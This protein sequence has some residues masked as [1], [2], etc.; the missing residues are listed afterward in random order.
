ML[1]SS[2]T[3]LFGFLPAVLALYFFLPPLLSLF[4]RGRIPQQHLHAAKN[5]VLLLSSLFFYAFGEPLYV[6]LMLGT[7][8]ADFLFGL[9]L[10]KSKKPRLV[11][12]FAVIFNL[13]LLFFFK[14]AAFFAAAIGVTVTPPRLPLGISFYTFQALSYV[15]DVYRRE[16]APTKSPLLF[17]TYLTLFPQLIAGPIVRYSD[18]AAEL[19]ERRTRAT[20]LYEGTLRFVAGLCKKVLLANPAG[21]LFTTHAARAP[22]SLVGAWL[23]LLGFTLQIYF[24][25]S[26]YS[27][28][29]IGLGRIFGFH[30][31]ENFNYPYTAIGFKD[32]WRRWHMTLT[33]F[34]HEYLYFPL[35]GSRRGV[36]RT[37]LNMLIVWL[38]TGLWHGAAWSF[39]LWG[40]Y[41]L[42]LLLAE[43]YVLCHIPLH[44][45]RF[46]K[47]L[48]TMLL[49]AVGW[50]I[51][52][53]DGS[54]PALTLARLGQFFPALIGLGE[55]GLAQGNQL[56]ELAR[57]IPFLALAALGAT[58]L[59]QRLFHRLETRRG[60]AVFATVL[61]LFGFVLALSSLA[62]SGF[63]PFLYFRF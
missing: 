6:L 16:V 31:P 43:R 5:G 40:L 46:I 32:F 58:A 51:F 30:F 33:S 23:A 10:P 47:H 52:A 26:G 59:P 60:G 44:V 57:H 49:V 41:Q 45:P 7:A 22:L 1:F 34:F 53:F 63:N 14:Y 8:M 48:L 39:L 19:R 36:P 35:G 29:A 61:P 18:M 3:F 37:V 15:V 17:T 42:L 25:F 4:C 2:F 12:T 11:L 56:Y 62:R 24:D 28:M 27:D 20:D 13:S 38:L 54:T 9:A 55:G 21:L 50:M